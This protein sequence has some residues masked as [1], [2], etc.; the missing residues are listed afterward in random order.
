MWPLLSSVCKQTGAAHEIVQILHRREWV[1]LDVAL[2]FT[3]SL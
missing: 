1:V 3:E 2:N